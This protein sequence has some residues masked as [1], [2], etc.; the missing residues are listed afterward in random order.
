MPSL[1]ELSK[2]KLRDAGDA[3]ETVI[4][5]RDYLPPGGML[6][7]LAGRWRD[8]IRELLDMPPLERV[9]RGKHRKPLGSLEPED[10]ERLA[11]AVILLVGSLTGYMDDPELSSRLT[12]LLGTL[13]FEQRARVVT[14]GAKA[15]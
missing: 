15:S 6:L 5:F 4:E 1:S 9:S 14:E 2:A 11:Q 12:D 3:I 10:L 7:M 13:A 8:D